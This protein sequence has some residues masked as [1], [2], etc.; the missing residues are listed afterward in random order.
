MKKKLLSIFKLTDS[1]LSQ[2]YFRFFQKKNFLLV[3]NFHGLFRNEK[4]KTLNLVDPRLWI[5]IEHFRLFVEYYLN[6]GYT[7][8]SPNHILDGLNNDKKYILITFDDGYFNN[9]CV[10]PI[11]EEYK[12]PAAFFISTNHVKYNKCFWWDVLY[13]EGIKN[14]MSI[15]NIT[16]ENQELKLITAGKKENYLRDMFGES[17]FKPICDIDRPF[18]SSELK[19]FSK[20]KYV[21][22]GNHTSDHNILT[23][24]SSNEIK[25][26]ILSA[27]DYIYDITGITPNIISYPNGNYSNEIIRISKEIGFK[28]GCAG[29]LKKNYLPIDCQGIECICLGRFN[30]Y[31]CDEDDEIIR[32]CEVFSLDLVLYDWIVRKLSGSR[33]KKR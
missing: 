31:G 20:E 15:N 12:I 30:F 27:Q 18:T 2:F 16:R 14:G 8:I 33:C 9:Q 11:L 3:F 5:T 23:N 13:R 26:L 6:H 7:F 10:L 17:A 21:F 25:S 22:L 1:L 19:D 24:Y 4:E 32:R 28:L 29:V